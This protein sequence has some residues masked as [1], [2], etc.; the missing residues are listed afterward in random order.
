MSKKRLKP[1]G[2][3]LS[4]ALLALMVYM[5]I[6]MLMVGIF[7]TGAGI[8]RSE[9]GAQKQFAILQ[10]R[11]ILASSAE[12]TLNGEEVNWY[13]GTDKYRLMFHNSRLVI[14]P[15]YQILMENVDGKFTRKQDHIY[16][17]LDGRSYQL[18]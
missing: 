2:F 18:S 3:T 15:G 4:E 9:A 17:L 14:R 13:R 5:L 16:L 7:Q 6:T 11:Q 12:I 1:N 10:L 8:S